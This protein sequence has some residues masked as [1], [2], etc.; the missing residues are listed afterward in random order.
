[1]ANLY[2]IVL[3]IFASLTWGSAYPSMEYSFNLGVGVFSLLTIRFFIG[4]LILSVIYFKELKKINKEEVKI[5]FWSSI[6]VFIMFFTMSYG[7]LYISAARGAALF[8]SYLIFTL[9]IKRFLKKV[10]FS[11]INISY[12]FLITI[13]IF[14]VNKNGF[15]LNGFSIGDFYSILSGFFFALNIVYLEQN[16]EKMSYKKLSV[17]QMFLCGLFSLI[18]INIFNEPPFPLTKALTLNI[19]YLSIVV[20]AFAYTAQNQ[21]LKFV[22][23][24]KASVILSTQSIFT[25]FISVIV[26]GEVLSTNMIIGIFFIGLGIFLYSMSTGEKNKK[27]AGSKHKSS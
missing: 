4:G 11:A 21:A 13:G 12:S 9:I 23:A 10:Q 20:T 17:I 3:L 5:C 24:E 22:D 27:L 18:F 2:G 25:I 8:S 14:Y 7:L 26:F 16:S 19:L 6:F 15:Y 1:M